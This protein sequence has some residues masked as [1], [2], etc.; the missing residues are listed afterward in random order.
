MT[1]TPNKLKGAGVVTNAEEPHPAFTI[2]SREYAHE[3]YRDVAQDEEIQNFLKETAYYDLSKEEW[4]IPA[5]PTSTLAVVE[6]VSLILPSIVARFVKPSHPG[7]V[8][9]VCTT[10]EASGADEDNNDGYRTLPFL[11]LKAAGPSFQ[12]PGPDD[13]DEPADSNAEPADIGFSNIATC[14]LVAT[15]PKSGTE[16]V[17]LEILEELASY[18]RYV[19][20]SCP[21]VCPANVKA[22][23]YF[24]SSPTECMSVRSPSPRTSFVSCTSTVLEHRLHHQSTSTE[25]LQRSFGWSLVCHQ[26]TKDY[27]ASTVASSGLSP[28]G[29]RRRERSARG[30]RREMSRSTPSWRRCRPRETR[31]VDGEQYVGKFKTRRLA[32]SS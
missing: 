31:F 19:L 21:V 24:E 30:T 15:E 1:G 5:H 9:E 2:T 29:G 17:E 12:M 26:Q 14:F 7:V 13:E 10:M 27:S 4:S 28:T 25:T 22:G 18:S 8:R 32:K 3:I 6:P 16:D 23:E 20:C 11:L